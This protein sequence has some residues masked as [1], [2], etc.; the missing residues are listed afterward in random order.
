MGVGRRGNSGEVGGGGGDL[1]DDGA[2]VVS[3]DE[4]A[5]G[6]AV[7]AVGDVGHR[8]AVVEVVGQSCDCPGD[9]SLKKGFARSGRQRALKRFKRPCER[10]VFVRPC[11]R[12]LP[13]D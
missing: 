5:G 6:V 4:S 7:G 9:G 10:L 3:G 2:A 12:N 11:G 1:V 8:L 13:N